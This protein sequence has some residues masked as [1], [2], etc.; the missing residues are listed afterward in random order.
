MVITDAMPPQLVVTGPPDAAG[1]IPV[2]VDRD[3][4]SPL[5]AT[6]ALVVKFT[7]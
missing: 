6:L 4:L 2:M 1:N 3:S 7:E 5:L